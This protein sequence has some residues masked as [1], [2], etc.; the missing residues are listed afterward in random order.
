MIEGTYKVKPKQKLF[1]RGDSQEIIHTFMV[2]YIVSTKRYEPNRLYIAHD[3]IEFYSNIIERS[4]TE[5]FYRNLVDIIA[6]KHIFDFN[7]NTYLLRP[8]ADTQNS[9]GYRINK[10]FSKTR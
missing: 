7:T 9:F 4:Q 5:F 2:K 10:L 6:Q 8:Q 1:A 3:N